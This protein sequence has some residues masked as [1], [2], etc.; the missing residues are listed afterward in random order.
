[1]GMCLHASAASSCALGI[2]AVLLVYGKTRC[3]KYF[4]DRPKTMLWGPLAMLPS[5]VTNFSSFMFGKS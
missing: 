4:N 5:R 2:V 3:V 1:M